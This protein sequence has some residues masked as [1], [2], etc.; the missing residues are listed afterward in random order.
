MP[1]LQSLALLFFLGASSGWSAPQQGAAQRELTV[2]VIN[3]HT[4]QSQ[5]VQGVR[6]S[7]SFVAGAEKVVDARDATNRR[8][9]ALLLVSPEAA[10]RGDLRIEVTG[11]SELVVFEPAD[12][13]LKA[14][15]CFARVSGPAARHRRNCLARQGKP[16]KQRWKFLPRRIFPRAG[17][18]P[19]TTSA[20]L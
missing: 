9:Q 10:Q 14:T 5:P 8:G 12:G 1:R 16:T 19:W 2:V 17:Q 18:A 7:L 13:E 15:L 4:D 20:M 11:T 3:A 6:V